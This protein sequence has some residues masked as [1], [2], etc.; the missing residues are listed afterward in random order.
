MVCTFVKKNSCTYLQSGGQPF[1]TL[2]ILTMLMMLTFFISNRVKASARA[3][4]GT[5]L[6][7]YT[8]SEIDNDYQEAGYQHNAMLI[9]FGGM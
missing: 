6:L 3:D 9:F 8:K 7:K 5:A 2:L 1:F 4:D